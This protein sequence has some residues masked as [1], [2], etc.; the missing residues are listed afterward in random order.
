MSNQ[1][2]E[3]SRVR[4]RKMLCHPDKVARLAER[5]GITYAEAWRRVRAK[6]GVTE[7]RHAVRKFVNELGNEIVIDVTIS[8]PGRRCLLSM[9]GPS[10]MV[11]SYMT[12]AEMEH[13][14]DAL[15]EA[16][17]NGR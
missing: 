7:P 12:R 6:A 14:C 8:D 3:A 10:S 11:E 15:T 13:L 17:A 1:P 4:A 2:T 5:S 9:E 16:L